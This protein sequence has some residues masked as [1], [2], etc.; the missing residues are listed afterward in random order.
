MVTVRRYRTR[1]RNGSALIAALL[2]AA[3]SAV[4]CSNGHRGGSE[5][6]TTKTSAL[7]TDYSAAWWPIAVNDGSTPAGPSLAAIASPTRGT[8]IFSAYSNNGSKIDAYG[9]HSNIELT[10]F[11]TTT[12]NPVDTTA[13]TA[14]SSDGGATIDLFWRYST[15]G[16]VGNT[17]WNGTSFPLSSAPPYGQVLAGIGAGG[18]TAGGTANRLDLFAVGTDHRLWHT[19]RNSGTWWGRWT[20]ELNPLPTADQKLASLPPAVIW[21]GDGVALHVFVVGSDGAVWTRM[22]DVNGWTDWRSLGGNDFQSGVAVTSVGT[23]IDLFAFIGASN[24]LR[25]YSTDGGTT[26]LPSSGWESVVPTSPNGIME[27][28]ID[29]LKRYVAPTAISRADGRIDLFARDSRK[30]IQLMTVRPA[31]GFASTSSRTIGSS[32]QDH[33][34]WENTAATCQAS[35]EEYVLLQYGIDERIE[36]ARVGSL[37][38]PTD[39]ICNLPSGSSSYLASAFEIRFPGGANT[40]GVGTNVPAPGANAGFNL[41]CPNSLSGEDNQIVRLSTGDLIAVR[42][43]KIC[44]SAVTC[45]G[46]AGHGECNGPTSPPCCDGQEV[47]RCLNGT[48]GTAAMLIYKSS[49]CGTSWTYQ[50]AADPCQILGIGGCHFT[51]PPAGF[52][53]KVW[54]CDAA[55]GLDRQE[56]Y[57]SGTDLFISAVTKGSDFA[58][59]TPVLLKSVDLGASWVEWLASTSTGRIG[60]SVVP[61]ELTAVSTHLVRFG[62]D[63][64]TPTVWIQSKD[65]PQDPVKT[66]INNS[67]FALLAPNYWSSMTTVARAASSAD[68]DYIRVA[69]S[70]TRV[71]G[72]V[73]SQVAKTSLVR[74]NSA[75]DATMVPNSLVTIAASSSQGSILFAT[76]VEADHVSGPANADERPPVAL[77]WVE[78]TATPASPADCL[79]SACNWGDVTVKAIVFRGA[80]QSSIVTVPQT[81]E[82]PTSW[83][84]WTGNGDYVHGASYYQA[85]SDRDRFFF[86]WRYETLGPGMSGARLLDVLR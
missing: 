41:F 16:S 53:D 37:D 7:S 1:I 77:F 56:A 9:T 40:G 24:L 64:S 45:T 85:S 68:G 83:T 84:T 2:V 31:A 34:G 70:G 76:L 50:G 81:L 25:R 79:S 54:T 72:G 19:A 74:V 20:D 57:A 38:A 51:S 86:H 14:A 21:R 44:S 52:E 82:G 49:D 62:I 5:G 71:V 66:P 73:T 12:L 36:R 43:A 67:G 3:M 23:R 28:S 78:T 39:T 6:T 65:T 59:A 48:T 8:E 32:C 60:N 80:S 61:A 75:H 69:Y 30:N 33:T 10:R 13:V 55:P 29:G 11:A 58:G 18:A 42:S 63:G 22:Y 46:P 26:W 35:G 15:D 27:V 4:R 47:Q 17:A